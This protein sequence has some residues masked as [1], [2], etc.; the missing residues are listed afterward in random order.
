VRAELA[1]YGAGLAEKPELVALNKID[2]LDEAAIETRAGALAAAARCDPGQVLCISGATGA[3]VPGLLRALLTGV[4][5]HRATRADGRPAVA[6]ATG[7]VQP[8]DA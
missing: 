4:Q 1:A 8:W 5:A 2:L 6:P 7:E 3:G